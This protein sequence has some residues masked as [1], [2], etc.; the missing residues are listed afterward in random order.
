MYNFGVQK[1]QIFGTYGEF[2][3]GAGASQIRA[4]YILTKVRPGQQGHWENQLASQMKPWREVFRIEEL[5][6][7]ELIQRDLDD[8]R[9]AHDLIPYLL[10]E[11]GHNARFFPPILAVMVPKRTD[12]SGIAPYYPAPTP[13]TTESIQVFGDLFDFRQVSFEGQA[14]PL[15]MINYNP[16]RTAMVIVDGQHRAMAVLALHRQLNKSWEADAFASYYSHVQVTQEDVAHVELPVCLI[17]FPDLYEGSPTV[18]DG[19]VDLT[20]VSRE[21][22]TVVNKQAKEVSQSRE[23]LLDD[24]DFAAFMMRQTLSI[25]KN[26]TVDSIQSARIYSFAFGDSEADNRSQVMAGQLEYCS[27]VAL[28][29][30]HA[31]AGFGLPGCYSIVNP[32]DV[33]DGRKVRNPSRPIEILQGSDAIALQ[34]LSRRSAKSHRPSDRLAVVEKVGALT[35][36]IMLPLFDRLRPFA[37]H[38]ETMQELK[39]AL[40]DA[41][42]VADPVQNKC[43]TLLFE[44][45]GTK[46]VFEEHTT[47]LKERASDLKERG[48]ALP[49][50][51]VTQLN[52]CEAVTKALQAREDEVRRN[53]ALLLFNIDRNNF[54]VNRDRETVEAEGRVIRARAKAIF[55]TVST[56][57]FQ[58]GYLMAGLSLVELLLPEDGGTY[59]TRLAATK[60]TSSLLIEGLNSFFQVTAT[61]HKTLNGYVIEPR[62][63]SFE[64]AEQGFRGLL[65]AG[66]VRELNEKQ[67][68]FFRYMILEIVHS[69]PANSAIQQ[70]LADPQW[71][72]Q[73]ARYRDVLPELLRDLDVLKQRYFDAAVRTA[74]NS[75]DFRR[76]VESSGMKARAE[77]K[78]EAEVREIEDKANED[79]KVATLAA[80]KEHLKASLKYIETRKAI[81]K[82]LAADPAVT[83]EEEE[84]ADGEDPSVSD[85]EAHEVVDPVQPEE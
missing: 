14:T 48:E 22:F 85:D 80:C 79:R 21:I 8:S 7:E 60:F 63:K 52:Y 46:H 37:V 77:G 10:G 9:V 28:H 38:N 81:L 84:I 44:G 19:R 57:A 15:A 35:D 27:A 51:L 25:F 2:S 59:D 11:S 55:D 5:T 12:R 4:Q 58:L 70:V 34:S 29:K 67:W 3:V 6:F 68:E 69:K 18:A 36:S 75:P 73:A 1:L 62:A 82:R 61:K 65:A 41:V 49:A 71:E 56:Q 74:L 23:L 43:R 66:N 20:T 13:E 30:M 78:S 17:F 40:E 32:D 47:R 83:N 42:N 45:S 54:S 24:E 53:R 64:A 33:T 50:H 26:R 76:E 31:A 16:Q 72:L 39:T